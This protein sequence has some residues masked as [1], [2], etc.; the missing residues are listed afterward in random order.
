[1]EIDR[2]LMN[3]ARGVKDFPKLEVYGPMP[4]EK[5]TVLRVDNDCLSEEGKELLGVTGGEPDPNGRKSTGGWLKL[6]G[7]CPGVC[8]RLWRP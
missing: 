2:K 6:E 7:L 8:L 3:L 1:M 5:T 4:G